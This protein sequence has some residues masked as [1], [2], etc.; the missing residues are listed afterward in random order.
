MVLLLPHEDEGLGDVE[1][2]LTTENLAIWLKELEPRP[3]HLRLPRFALHA[4]LELVDA[5]RAMGMTDAFGEQ[6]DF[7]GMSP[8]HGLFVSDVV[9][10]VRIEVDER[11]TVGA[12]A[13]GLAMSKGSR[14]AQ[15]I[16][17]HPFLFVIRD[18]SDGRVWFLGRVV[19]PTG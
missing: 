3:V 14:P 12:A 9:H 6:A 17:D 15:F 19:R 1:R 7:S 18:R 4:R 10:S 8:A 2:M 16:A 5:L 11:G 13:S